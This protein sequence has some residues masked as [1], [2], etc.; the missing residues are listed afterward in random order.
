MNR[1]QSELQKSHVVRVINCGDAVTS[2]RVI[3]Y[4]KLSF[5]MNN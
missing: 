3:N 5:V 1:V 4:Q 2:L